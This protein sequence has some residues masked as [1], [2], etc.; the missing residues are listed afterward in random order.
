MLTYN[1]SYTNPQHHF[2]DIKVS[3]THITQ[4]ETFLQ[5]PSW[6]PGR[7]ELGNFAKNVQY[8]SVNDQNGQKLPFRKVKKDRWLVN[9][10]GIEAIT[11]RYNYFAAQLDAGSTWLDEDLLYVNPVNCLLYI[12]G[13]QDEKCQVTLDIPEDYQLG[14]GLPSE[15]KTLYADNYDQLADSPFVASRHLQHYQYTAQDIPFHIWAVGTT[16][17]N[18]QETIA[19]FRGFTLAQIETMGSFPAS[20]YHF[21]FHFLPYKAYHGVEHQNSTVITLG[22]N[23]DLNLP[24]LYRNLL[25]ISSH[26]LFHAWNIKK[27]RPAEMMPYDYTT[28]NYFPTGFVAEGVTTYY[29]DLFLVR[30]GI[31]NLQDYLAELNKSL[32]RH[33]Y[34]G[35]RLNHSLIDSSLDLWL[36]GYS[37]GI[38]NRKV[39]I[40]VKGSLVSLILDLKLR[41]ITDNKGSLDD[42]MR[43]LL[44]NFGYKNRGYHYEDFQAAV[45]KIADQPLDDYFEQFIGGTEPLEEHLEELVDYVGLKIVSQPNRLPSQRYYGLK[46]LEKEGI[47]TVADFYPGSPAE[48]NLARGDELVA[49]NGK[50]IMNYNFDELLA[51]Y[52]EAVVSFYRNNRM[53]HEAL[54][55]IEGKEFFTDLKIVP[56]E[57]ATDEALER[58]SGWLGLPV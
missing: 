29:G 17:L 25:G 34:N 32:Q 9:T 1:L 12:E 24:D 41:K 22:P 49:V 16:P 54:A 50:R 10:K 27:I 19:E 26:E 35:G 14:S 30:A 5:L 48:K 43:L 39:S 31:F 36:D 7:Y 45:A 23:Y 2:I 11:I 40:Y 55:P 44:E 58:R 4:S 21:I 15:N 47:T 37:P 56:N 33:L 57:A 53:H 52:P 42:V 6:R 3:V 20:D 13:M 51:M 28:E 38:P 46:L 8:F 18:W